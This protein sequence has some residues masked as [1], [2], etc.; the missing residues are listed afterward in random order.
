MEQEHREVARATELPLEDLVLHA[1]AH[2]HEPLVPRGLPHAVVAGEV[3][4]LGEPEEHAPR[5]V[6]AVIRLYPVDEGP[7]VATGTAHR[8]DE[9]L[10]VAG[11]EVPGVSDLLP[12]PGVDLE[13][14]HPLGNEEQ[15]REV[16]KRPEEL[17]ELLRGHAHAVQRHDQ[18]IAAA[19]PVPLRLVEQVPRVDAE[20]L[21]DDVRLGAH[22][23]GNLAAARGSG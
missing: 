16:A 6:H 14:V 8:A 18:G 17:C 7:Q 22:G 5:G 4:A 19:L 1:G 9:V 21:L 10:V 2:H 13:R 15:D 12:R 23:R 20:A 11:V 3:A